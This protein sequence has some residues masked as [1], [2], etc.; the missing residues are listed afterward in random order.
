MN[1][2][3]ISIFITVLKLKHSP[4]YDSVKF[5][6][7]V[8]K[9]LVLITNKIYK[10]I[11][12]WRTSNVLW[13][14]YPRGNNGDIAFL[15]HI[16]FFLQIWTLVIERWSNLLRNFASSSN[17]R[18][19]NETSINSIKL[20][21]SEEQIPWKLHKIFDSLH[22]TWLN[23]SSV[24]KIPNTTSCISREAEICNTNPFVPTTEQR[25]SYSILLDSAICFS[26]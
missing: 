20:I 23:T 5:A 18:I 9:S 3:E 12:F 13:K 25:F 1:L 6:R 8:R 7:A 11:Q 14:H 26:L 2:L 24:P 17:S 19:F 21:R 4:I 15:I 22:F 16:S 10:F